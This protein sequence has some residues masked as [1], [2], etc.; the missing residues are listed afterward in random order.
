MSGITFTSKSYCPVLEGRTGNLTLYNDPSN[1]VFNFQ[2][3]NGQ[4]VSKSAAVATPPGPVFALSSADNSA[5]SGLFNV[6]FNGTNF[7]LNYNGNTANS[8]ISSRVLST[9]LIVSAA[10]IAWFN[11]ANNSF[12]LFGV[13]GSTGGISYN[14]EVDY[15]NKPSV[16]SFS[17]TTINADGHSYTLAIALNKAFSPQQQGAFNTGNTVNCVCSISGATSTGT[18]VACS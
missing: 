16:A 12:D 5:Y 8:S 11:S 17:P 4:A 18:P 7:N 2:T 13:S 10:D 14:F 9:S 15:M 3:Y 6:G 1:P